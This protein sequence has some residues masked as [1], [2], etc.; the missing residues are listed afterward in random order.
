MIGLEDLSLSIA[1]NDGA[2]RWIRRPDGV[3]IALYHLKNAANE[4]ALLFGHCT[5]FAAGSYL[6]LLRAV[7]RSWPTLRIF[8]FDARGHGAST[9]PDL[10]LGRDAVDARVMALDLAA[11]AAAVREVIGPTASLHYAAHSLG[12]TAAL[13]V[14]ALLA[15]TPF[16]S[17]TLFE[18]PILPAHDHPLHDRFWQGKN[19]L[20]KGA[21]QRRS[22]WPDAE[23]LAFSLARNSVFQ[24]IA[25][26]LLLHH[27]R[28]VLRPDP[29]S[30]YV[31][32]CSPAVEAAT[33]AAFDR[34]D[35]WHALPQLRRLAP[36]LPIRVVVSDLSRATLD[37]V[38]A[39]A[40]DLAKAIHG[41]LIDIPS[42]GHML[43]FEQPG[44]FHRLLIALREF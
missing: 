32:S 12:A 9:S 26:E 30:G 8:A 17:L 11:V 2:C 27:A 5:G 24:T 10:S 37:P 29:T 42:C 19:A 35:L 28:A 1:P 25:P 15:E 38:T 40:P 3:E 18:P 44:A 34:S 41:H 43:C 33:F 4:P 13:A 16:T 23:S 6:P 36:H 7:Q 22:A 14:Y 20:A 39:V 31:L 21:A